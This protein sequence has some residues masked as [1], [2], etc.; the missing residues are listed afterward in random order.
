[1]S[2]K[3]ISLLT[4]DKEKE[5]TKLV[6]ELSNNGTFAT[7]SR[8]AETFKQPMLSNQCSK[9]QAITFD[10]LHFN[11]SCSV[12]VSY[13]STEFSEKLLLPHIAYTNR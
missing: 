13:Y 3:G 1:M 5:D 7:F 12:V 6:V 9:T 4:Q 11:G 8:A 10:A 2:S